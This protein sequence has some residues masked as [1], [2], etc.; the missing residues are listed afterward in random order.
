M[1]E[2]RW[3]IWTG[4]HIDND[5][6]TLV[7]G[8]SLHFDHQGERTLVTIPLD[9][10]NV[11]SV[12]FFVRLGCTT[13]SPEPSNNPVYLQYSVNGG[14]HWA[15]IEQ[16][17]FNYDSNRPKYYALHLPEKSRT[18]ASQLRWWQPS[19]DGTYTDDWAIDQVCVLL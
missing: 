13:V 4:A 18:A 8:K 19:M 10:S 16:F 12:Q 1:N 15:S 14:I 6:D 17:D 2:D 9:L 3:V 5:C 7:S 11:S